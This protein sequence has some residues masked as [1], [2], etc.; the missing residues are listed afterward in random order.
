MNQTQMRAVTLVGIVLAALI[1]LLT[2]LGE[3]FLVLFRD[4]EPLRLLLAGYHPYAP[5]VLIAL[6]MAQVLLAPLPGQVLGLTSGYFFGPLWGTIYSTIGN[7]LGSLLAFLLARTLGRPLVERLV[8]PNILSQIDKG[9][10]ERGLAFFFMLFLLPFLPDD[11]AC[12][13]AGLTSLPLPSLVL[14]SL[15]GRLPGLA[16]SNLIGA[17]MGRFS[18]AQWAIVGVASAAGAM[19]FWRYQRRI[20]EAMFRLLC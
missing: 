8:S 15:V 16:A 20:E 3:R 10:Q 5:L 13:A 4:P 19:L 7:T 18:T 6:Q 1:L 2:I 14:A 12:Y 9:A 17:G 11:L